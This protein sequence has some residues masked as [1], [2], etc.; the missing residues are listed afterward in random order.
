[1][2]SHRPPIISGE[3]E[4]GH[5][6]IF[7]DVDV[8][9]KKS[10]LPYFENEIYSST[11]SNDK[12]NYTNTTTGTDSEVHIWAQKDPSKDLGH[13]NLCPGFMVFKLCP[14]TIALVDKWGELILQKGNEQR[15]QGTFNKLISGFKG[16]DMPTKINPKALAQNLFVTGNRYFTNNMTDDERS[17]VVVVHNNGISGYEKKVNRFKEFNLWVLDQNKTK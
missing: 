3:L 9:W 8:I 13:D 14:Q 7:S 16:Y 17:D 10:P 1:M 4:K 11:L 12:A 2:M 6:V 15:N 5:D